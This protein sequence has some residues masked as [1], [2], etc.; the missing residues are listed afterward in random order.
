MPGELESALLAAPAGGPARASWT[1]AIRPRWPHDDPSLQSMISTLYAKLSGG[2]YAKIDWPNG[3]L[4]LATAEQQPVDPDLLSSGQRDLLVLL[5]FLAPWLQAR[6]EHGRAPIGQ[7]PLLLDEPFLSL[8]G[9]GQAAC[10]QL[11][12]SLAPAQQI[13]LAARSPIAEQP[14]DHRIT[15]PLAPQAAEATNR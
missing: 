8:D 5:C 6:A 3:H 1:D 10:L 12:R 7:F 4:Q 14:T 13:I 2:R 15:L 11:L 9:A